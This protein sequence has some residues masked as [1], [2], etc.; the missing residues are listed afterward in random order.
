MDKDHNLSLKLEDIDGHHD[1]KV[2]WEKL[3][4]LE[5]ANCKCSLGAKNILVR[6]VNKNSLL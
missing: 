4:P 2:G 5:K 1:S 6:V 3:L